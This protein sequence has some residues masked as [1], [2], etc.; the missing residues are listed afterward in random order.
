VKFTIDRRALEKL[1]KAVASRQSELDKISEEDT[2]V[3]S[4]CAGRVFY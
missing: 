3:L 1:L 4:A 2:V